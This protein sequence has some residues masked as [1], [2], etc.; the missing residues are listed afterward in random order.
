MKSNSLDDVAYQFVFEQMALESF[1]TSLIHHN[2]K[3]TYI[4]NING[5]FDGK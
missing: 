1:L 5:L 2:L 4:I 3:L